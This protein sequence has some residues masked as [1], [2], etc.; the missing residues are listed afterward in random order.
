MNKT[1][2]SIRLWQRDIL[3]MIR[4]EGAGKR[5]TARM[6]AF[7]VNGVAV[8]LMVVVF[9]STAGLTGLEIGIAGGSALVGQKLLEAIF[10]EDAVRRMATRARTMLDARAREVL[11]TSSAIYLDELQAHSQPELANSLSNIIAALSSKEA[12]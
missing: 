11:F 3:D 7:G 5:K 9:V 6:A 1:S 4:Q 10:G 8:I 2:E 12:H